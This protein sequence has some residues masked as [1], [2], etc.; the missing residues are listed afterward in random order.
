MS[1]NIERE[2]S[3]LQLDN[4]RNYPSPHTTALERKP[5]GGAVVHRG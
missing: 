2:L 3:N 1:L 4:S 5:E